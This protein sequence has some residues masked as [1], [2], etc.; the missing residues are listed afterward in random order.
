MQRF[1]KQNK[2]AH[3][4]NCNS[5]LTLY[6]KEEEIW[7]ATQEVAEG[8]SWAFAKWPRI[9]GVLPHNYQWK[10][11]MLLWFLSVPNFCC[12]K[13][14]V[15]D[16]FWRRVWKW[17]SLWDALTST[18]DRIRMLCLPKIEAKSC[19]KD[20]QHW[21]DKYPESSPWYQTIFKSPTHLPHFWPRLVEI[22]ID[23]TLF[24]FQE[25]RPQG[26]YW[27]RSGPTFCF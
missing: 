24:L 1:W 21:D 4:R 22:T 2:S 11:T 25:P 18:S 14:L 17:K 5:L 27:A 20:N 16:N 19:H 10:M 9:I 8:A 23:W 15:L 6:C 12:S 3:C 13:K 7:V 26:L